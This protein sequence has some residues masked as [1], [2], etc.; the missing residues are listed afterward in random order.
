MV[1]SFRNRTI[2]TDESKVAKV[3]QR[4]LL[5]EELGIEQ[6]DFVAPMDRSKLPPYDES[7]EQYKEYEKAELEFSDYLLNEQPIPDRLREYL[8]RTKEE[9]KLWHEYKHT[10]YRKPKMSTEEAVKLIEQAMTYGEHI[11]EK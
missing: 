11:N 8:L 1:T 9:R 10:H 7:N 6:L 4:I 2:K 5:E 3:R